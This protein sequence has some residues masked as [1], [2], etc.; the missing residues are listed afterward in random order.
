MGREPR[1]HCAA[2]TAA[3]PRP[4][5]GGRVHRSMWLGK[6]RLIHKLDQH[7]SPPASR[8]TFQVPDLLARFDAAGPVLIEVKSKRSPKLSFTSDYLGRL[9]SYA[10]LLGL[11][12]L[13]AWK[14]HGVWTLFEA[15]HLKKART[16]FNIRFGEAM[17]QNLLGVLVGDVSY[18]IAPGAG[19]V[20]DCRKEALLGTKIEGDGTT[21]QW[22]MRIDGVRLTSRRGKPRNDLDDDVT[23]LF[24]TWISRSG[25]PSRRP[26]SMSPSKPAM[27][28]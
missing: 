17:R 25:R 24:T 8:A 2:D 23:T 16:N 10:D 9:S 20:L 14:F 3:R 4:S 13:I 7:Q 27:R 11:P 6:T 22:Q 12:L 19:V 15:R 21:E 26:T 28:A 1:E 18:K 5:G